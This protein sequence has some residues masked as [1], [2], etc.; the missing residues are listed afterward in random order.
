[1]NKWPLFLFSAIVASL[2]I[3]AG[4]GKLWLPLLLEIVGTNNNS[5]QALTSIFQLCLGVLTV[6]LAIA[7]FILSRRG[8][9]HIAE[10][11]SGEDQYT[12]SQNAYKEYRDRIANLILSYDL[13]KSRPGDKVSEIARTHTI[14]TMKLLDG[15]TK[16]LTVQHL[17]DLKLMGGGI[18]DTRFRAI[19][20]LTDVDFRDANLAGMNLRG[21]DMTGVNLSNASLKDTFLAYADL[22][23]STVTGADFED[24]DL[25][26]ANLTGVIGLTSSQIS[27]AGSTENAE[28]PPLI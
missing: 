18:N 3:L 22:S 23:R 17:F 14:A 25:Q 21:V 8:A 20:D 6:G 9:N 2:A 28:L 19:I 5:I 13:L 15:T 4:T 24:A 11:K 27:R 16:G 12:E 10:S 7:T 1:M 26:S